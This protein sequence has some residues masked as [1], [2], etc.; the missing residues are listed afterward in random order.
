MKTLHSFFF[1][2]ERIDF[3]FLREKH[4]IFEEFVGT[5]SLLCK[6]LDGLLKG[7]IKK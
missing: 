6:C 5:R 4:Y 7:F 1:L 3:S 2:F